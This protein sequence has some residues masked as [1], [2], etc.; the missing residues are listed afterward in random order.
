M[1]LT[2]APAGVVSEKVYWTD[3]YYN[4]IESVTLDGKFRQLFTESKPGA[5]LQSG[6]VTY[7]TSLGNYQ[8]LFKTEQLS[9]RT[10]W[11][12]IDIRK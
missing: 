10:L 1:C 4:R 6:G 12:T 8:S 7:M 9:Q 3:S 11:E 2:I 5:I